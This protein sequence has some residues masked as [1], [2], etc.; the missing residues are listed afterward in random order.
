MPKHLS[1]IGGRIVSKPFTKILGNAAE[2]LRHTKH[3]L[4][5]KLYC[6]S[7]IEDHKII[8]KIIAH[9]KLTFK[10]ERPPPPKAQLTWTCFSFYHFQ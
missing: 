6:L 2:G 1:Q 9:L 7:F 5:I 8:D 10:A 3:Q 4:F